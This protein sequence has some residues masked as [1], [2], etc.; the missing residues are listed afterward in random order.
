MGPKKALE[1]LDKISKSMPDFKRAIIDGDTRMLVSVFGFTKKTAEKLIFA[2]RGKVDSWSVAGPLKWQ[3]VSKTSEESE[4][5]SG[6]LNLGYDE[7]EARE[8]VQRVKATVGE[9]V[10]TEVL[11]KESLKLLGARI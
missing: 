4:A 8:I 5:I 1:C 7:L 2:L 6:L 11:L 3:D 9:G 10:T